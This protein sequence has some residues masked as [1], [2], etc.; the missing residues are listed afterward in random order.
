MD[1]RVRRAIAADIRSGRLERPSLEEIMR[2]DWDRGGCYAA[3]AE[4]CFV[5]PD[6]HC[7]HGRPSWML[8]MGVI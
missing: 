3:C 5:E 7:E 1:S 8:V 4:Y 6:G 2:D